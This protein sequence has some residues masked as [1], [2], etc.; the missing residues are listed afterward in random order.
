MDNDRN[1]PATKGDIADLR[2]EVKEDITALRT[3]VKEQ[4]TVLRSE[5]TEQGAMIR[6]EMQHTF[7]DLKETIHDAQTALLQAFYSFAESN[8]MRLTQAEKDA[9]VLKE[10]MALYEQRLTDL[11]RKVKFPNHPP[12]AQ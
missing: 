4:I 10:R 1:V 5:M 9:A 7:D 2:A 6:S 11:E 8:Q 3:E 12:Q